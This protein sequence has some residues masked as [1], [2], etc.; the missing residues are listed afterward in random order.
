MLTLLLLTDSHARPAR[1]DIVERI[2][3]PSILADLL[4]QKIFGAG[5]ELGGWETAHSGQVPDEF[6]PDDYFIKH[7]GSHVPPVLYNELR[8]LQ[9]MTSLPFIRQWAWE[10]KH[11]CEEFSIGLT[12]YPNYFDGYDETR[13][14]VMGQYLQRQTEAYRSAHIRT[15]AH[16]VVEWGMPFSKAAGYLLDHI[17]AVGGIFDLDPGAKP[18]CLFDLPENCL[19][20]GSVLG[21]VLTDWVRAGRSSKMRCVSVKSPF[22]LDLM[23]YGEVYVGAYFVTPDFELDEK[24]GLYEPMDFTLNTDRIS[25]DGI[26]QNT[27]I[28]DMRREG[29]AGWAAPVCSSLLPLPHGYWNADYFALGLPIV[30]PYC[31][32]RDAF[33][34]VRGGALELGVEDEHFATTRIWNDAWRPTYPRGGNTRCG[35]VAELEK[36]IFETLLNRVPEGL[37]IA[38][39]IKTRVW[40]RPS[41]YGEYAMEERSAVVMDDAI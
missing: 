32:P 26:A 8:K 35:A 25:V 16:A 5:A 24:R 2:R 21:A 11:L 31:L 15:F 30:T 41:Q 7:K 27:K 13:G 18:D 17:P 29:K 19:R 14:E 6:E 37:K 12:L 20:E 38:W 39:F 36:E 4:L 22:P 34:Q 23:K 28:E 9:R 3:R 1:N 33:I 40:K 10:W